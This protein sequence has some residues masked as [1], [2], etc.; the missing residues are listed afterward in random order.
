MGGCILKLEKRW[1]SW[2][3]T[4]RTEASVR[5]D[6]PRK[7]PFHLVASLQTHSHPLYTN[8]RPHLLRQLSPC[9]TDEALAAGTE[10]CDE[11]GDYVLDLESYVQASLEFK[12]A[13]EQIYCEMCEKQVRR[14]LS[15]TSSTSHIRDHL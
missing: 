2:T 12:A 1:R 9:C 6:E 11:Y 15:R 13:N 14:I 7:R 8:T 3:A 5:S 4:L 10:G